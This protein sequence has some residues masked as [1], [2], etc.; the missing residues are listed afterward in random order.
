MEVAKDHFG[1]YSTHI[2]TREAEKIIDEHNTSEV[3]SHVVYLTISVPTMQYV[4][5]VTLHNNIRVA[6]V[7]V[8]VR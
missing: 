4:P 3:I 8:H 1:Q 6:S 2:F 5:F 7:D